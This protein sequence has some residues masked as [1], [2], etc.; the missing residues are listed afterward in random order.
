MRLHHYCRNPGAQGVLRGLSSKSSRARESA[1][2]PHTRWQPT[3]PLAVPCM[4]HPCWYMNAC[5]WGAAAY[6]RHVSH[7]AYLCGC[8][9]VK[10]TCSLAA[11]VHSY[12]AY[13][14]L[15][16][17]EPMLAIRHARTRH[18]LALTL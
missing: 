5:M 10:A 13:Q 14:M 9:R 16:L 4:K 2:C 1:S 18:C 17:S 3:L 6:Q 8:L 7:C 15:A 11:L 12:H